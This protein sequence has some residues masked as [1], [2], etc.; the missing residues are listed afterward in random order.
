MIVMIVRWPAV[1]CLMFAVCYLWSAGFRLSH[2]QAKVFLFLPEITNDLS[3]LLTLL[4]VPS[5]LILLAHLF[6][7]M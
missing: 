1:C 4:L 3:L 6:L 2:L 7:H 5:Q